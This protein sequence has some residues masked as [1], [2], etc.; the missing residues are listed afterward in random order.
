[1]Q[2]SI[3]CFSFISGLGYRNNFFFRSF[4]NAKHQRKAV[5]F[6]SENPLLDFILKCCSEKRLEAFKNIALC[7]IGYL[8]KSFLMKMTFNA[9]VKEFSDKKNYFKYHFLPFIQFRELKYYTHGT[10][11]A[12]V[13]NNVD[14]LV[15]FLDGL[16][17]LNESKR[18]DLDN[19]IQNIKISSRNVR[20]IIS[21]RN[22]SFIDL[23]FFSKS[24]QLYLEKYSDPHDLKLK[25]LMKDYEGTPIVDLLT[26]PTYRNFIL[27]KEIAKD[28]KLEI[29]YNLLV[30]NNLKN[31]KNKRDRSNNITSRMISNIEINLIIKELSE[32]CYILF[33]KGEIVFS[34][35]SLKN[36]FNNL[37]H[38]IF[39]INSA[40]I[41][42]YDEN[43]IS[44]ISNFY[45]EYFITFALMTKSKKIIYQVFFTMGNIKI[46]CIDILILFLNCAST[47]SKYIYNYLKRKIVKDDIVGILLC[48][49][50]M[51]TNSKR[52]EYF[53]SIYNEYKKE[54]KNIYY[55]RF[56]QVF[57]PLKNINNMAQR[58]QQLLPDNY[59]THTVNYLKSEI[60]G[61]LQRPSKDYITSFG[62]AI[63]LLIPFIKTFG[64]IMSK[65]L[66]KKSQYLL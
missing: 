14:P 37:D 2:S 39:V 19:E 49:F 66:L 52:Y 23:D 40:I 30:Q 33:C 26:I 25:E 21:G 55:G 58:M 60:L 3:Y 4:N 10:I 41:D 28:S 56:R 35:S 45:Y 38:F 62:N 5:L 22:S 13:K 51:L 27:E 43:N 31:D 29:F 47:K 46:S 16:D 8:G 36:H 61:F 59:K 12:V 34:E 18:M 24:T 32:F 42:Y 17:E 20:F 15:I 7:G 6:A 63:I 64:Q 54:N 57:G 44:F 11:E 53:I 9:L 48:E 50:D 1:M 65:Q